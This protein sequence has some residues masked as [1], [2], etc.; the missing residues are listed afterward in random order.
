M[1]IDSSS[2]KKQRSPVLVTMSVLLAGLCS[3]ALA[4]AATVTCSGPVDFGQIASC[5]PGASTITVLPSG[6]IS[7]TGCATPLGIAYN[8][9]LCI[10]NNTT[11]GTYTVMITPTSINL[12][13]GTPVMSVNDF[14]MRPNGGATA[15]SSFTATD[16]FL[17]IDVGATLNMNA[18]QPQGTY[19]GSY[20][21]TVN[22]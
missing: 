4:H 15:G 8:P 20:T 9:G 12:A 2:D 21:L 16:L 1:T 11:T 18:N 14:R 13:G 6:A 3:P 22:Y 5:G 10:A 7:S 19:T 17:T